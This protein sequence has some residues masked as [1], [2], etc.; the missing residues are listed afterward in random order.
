M[1]QADD[2]FLEK[3][4]VILEF[5]DVADPSLYLPLPDGWALAVADIVDST[6]A[7]EGGRY[8]AVN[9][10]G[11]GVI[12]AIANVLGKADLPFVFGGDGAVVAI[13]P[14]GLDQ[15]RDAL[16]RAQS[17]VQ[18]DMDMQL[19]AA[20]VPVSEIRANGLDVR[21][22]RYRASENATYAMFSGGGNSWA[23]ARMKQGGYTVEAAPS[24]ARPDLTGLSCRWN[25]IQSNHGRIVSIIAIPGPSGNGRAFRKLVADV[26]MLANED[27]RG[28]HPVPV[29]GPELGFVR[30][31][32]G[33]EAKAQAGY[34]DLL[35][36]LR[37]SLSILGQVFL[38]RILYAAGMSLG[39]FNVAIY[40]R[41]VASNTDFRKFDDGLK[42]TVDVSSARLLR[43]KSA[44]EKASADGVC[45]YGLHEQDA[46][47]MTCIVPTA[48]S[49]DHMHF[50]DGASGGYATAAARLKAQMS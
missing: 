4:P 18:D 29:D 42:M 25:P 14:D 28:G 49:H 7:I 19:R 36:R 15:A 23:E 11:A 21:V 50:V 43:I 44:L 22:A 39:R 6:G 3:L 27:G 46:A 40:K 10:A 9:M 8:K 45:Y 26:V 30:E 24:G 38:V 13:P 37:R 1:S 32:L 20:L 33:M 5:E 17:W 34:G 41:E 12:S 16:A 2:D 48:L 47:L 35:M 31:G